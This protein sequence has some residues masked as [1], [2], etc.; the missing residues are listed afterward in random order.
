MFQ[1]SKQVL[2]HF[3]KPKNVGKIENAD[4][5]GKLTN[6]ACGDL[7]VVYLKIGKKKIKGKEKE[8]IK[9][10]KFQTLGCPAAIS[11]SDILCELVKGKTLEE[12]EKISDKAITEKL[13]G[14][15]VIKL[16]C[17]VLGSRTLRNAIENYK[18]KK[19]KKV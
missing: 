18:N 3:L 17:S 1:Y 6:D 8:F 19:K 16:H 14:L 11:A 15:P 4:G 13:G 9:Q 10:A 2:K 5:I 7:M 12:A